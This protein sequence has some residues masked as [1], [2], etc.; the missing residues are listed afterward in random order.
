MKRLIIPV[1]GIA[2]LSCASAQAATSLKTKQDKLSY[3]MG[4]MT[5][6]AF[7]AHDIDIDPKVFEMGLSD[8][9]SGK[10][11]K[12]SEKKI[13]ETLANFQKE[14]MKKMQV[15]VKKLAK[16]NEKQSVAFL[17]SNKSKPGVKTTSSGL[18]YKIIKPG[19]GKSPTLQDV[20]TVN[21]E[22]KL[23]NGKVFDSSYQRGKPA[24]FPVKNVIKGWQEALVMMKPGAVWELYIPPKLAY[25]KKG[26]PGIIGPNQTLIFKINL[27][28]V[29]KK[30]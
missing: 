22:G 11:T 30:K 28:S 17:A 15:K 14:S 7:K 4:V 18:Q 5:G 13:R 20:V 16:A 23:L 29:K 2:L 26:A 19:K 24:T 10:K 27:I 3:S 25:G 8:G 1:F 12:L 9:I 6:R 21:Y